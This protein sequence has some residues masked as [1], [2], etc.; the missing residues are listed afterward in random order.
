MIMINAMVAADPVIDLRYI[1]S[2]EWSRTQKGIC[3]GSG[4]VVSGVL[5]QT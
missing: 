3:I 1:D 2:G 4:F 5:H